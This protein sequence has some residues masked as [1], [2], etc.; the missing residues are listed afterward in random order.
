MGLRCVAGELLV[1][2]YLKV[3]CGPKGS[4]G[5]VDRMRRVVGKGKGR[6]AIALF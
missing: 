4:R 5:I 2:D 3:D 1:R 6:I